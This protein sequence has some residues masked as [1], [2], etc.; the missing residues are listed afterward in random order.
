MDTSRARTPRSRQKATPA[1]PASRPTEQGRAGETRKAREATHQRG[2]ASAEPAP[3]D[4]LDPSLIVRTLRA[5]ADELERDPGL[6]SRVAAA[7]GLTTP[8]PASLAPDAPRPA[9]AP[10]D[11]DGAHSAKAAEHPERAFQPRIVTGTS[12]DLG[13]GIP[14]PFALRA[15]L[16]S[17]G[18][19]AALAELRLGTLRAILREYALDPDGRISRQNDASRI[20]AHIV[21]A[22]ATR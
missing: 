22:V 19:A 16:G 18:L 20:R 12:S 8:S 14:D 10:G 21:R 15:R 6:A 7:S 9:E 11:A 17:D 5:V 2:A 4:P 3:G 13:P 1:K